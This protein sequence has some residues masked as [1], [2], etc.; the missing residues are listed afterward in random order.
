[1]ETKKTRQSL[2]INRAEPHKDENEKEKGKNCL[3]KTNAW[4][5]PLEIFYNA[6]WKRSDVLRAEPFQ[7]ATKNKA[8]K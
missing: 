6:T 3:Y 1:M 4:S 2:P 5:V 7:H 8:T